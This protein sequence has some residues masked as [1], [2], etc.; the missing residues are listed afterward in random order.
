M[1]RTGS[2]DLV[3]MSG[4]ARVG[5][6]FA[7]Q[8][9]VRPNLKFSLKRKF[10]VVMDLISNGSYFQENVGQNQ[11]E[12]HYALWCNSGG[13]TLGLSKANCVI[14]FSLSYEK[15]LHAF[16]KDMLDYHVIRLFI[17]N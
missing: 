13:T 9:Y 2:A 15:L 14:F 1:G 12:Q 4:K 6:K 5:Y 17:V 3:T 16:E 8:N 7:L 11:K 10:M